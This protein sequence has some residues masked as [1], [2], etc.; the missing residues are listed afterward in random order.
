MSSQPLE[1]Y[2][3]SQ[4]CPKRKECSVIDNKKSLDLLLLSSVALFQTVLPLI[5][6]YKSSRS[7][8][9]SISIS[10]LF[11]A[12]NKSSVSYLNGCYRPHL[13]IGTEVNARDT[14]SMH[15]LEL[16]LGTR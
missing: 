1:S 3:S 4:L 15:G 10:T 11:I 13:V 8:G 9:S 16:D 14:D 5:P 6:S 2:Q 7:E 12:V